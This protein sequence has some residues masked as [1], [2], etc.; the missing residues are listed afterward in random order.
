M[1]YICSQI[2]L[3]MRRI[4]V[5]QL[6]E[7]KKN[8]P[9]RKPLLLQGA[10][11]VGKSW[12]VKEFGKTYYKNFYNFNFENDAELRSYFEGSLRPEVIIEKLSLFIGKKIDSKDTLIF[13]D[14]I[15]SCPKALTSLKYFN[16][17]AP[18]Y[19]I[20]AA[21]SLLG[22]SIGKETT[23]PVGK[24]TFLEMYPMNF[25][26]FLLALDEDLLADYIYQDKSIEQ[27]DEPTHE[28]MIRYYKLHMYLGGMPEVIQ[29]YIN[30]R[31]PVSARRIQLDILDAYEND[32]SKYNT[33]VN[34]IKVSEI[35]NSIPEQLTK[36]NKKFKYS[37]VKT[38]ARHSHFE[39]AIHWLQRNGLVYVVNQLADIKLP[40]G[41]YRQGD[42]YKIYFIDSGLLGAK[43]NLPSA[44]VLDPVAIFKHYNGALVENYVCG[45]LKKSLKV[46]PYYWKYERGSAEVDFVFEHEGNIIPL[47][48]KSGTNKNTLG[49]RNFE[50]RYKVKKV[51]RTSPR[52]LHRSDTFTNVP[53]YW[54]YGLE[55][56]LK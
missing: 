6:L 4:G 54:L 47:E 21:G 8:H 56:F 20:I 17:D 46:K 27:L 22:I 5:N 14:E 28:K 45:E 16:E 53:L 29:D 37:D 7:W 39:L 43:L 24:V 55:R 19:D 9:R 23:F 10:R 25:Y 33:P 26:E 42:N 31:D 15:Q 3:N 1:N 13:F 50:E 35:W 51:F 2:Y 32:F 44:V 48:V 41:G 40:L 11:Q 52:N 34:A 12:V 49:L 30:K 18:Q 38:G 36:E